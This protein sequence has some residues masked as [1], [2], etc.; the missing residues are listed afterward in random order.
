MSL[1]VCFHCP[2]S[3]DLVEP[4]LRVDTSPHDPCLNYSTHV[5]VLV[6]YPVGREDDE[7][8]MNAG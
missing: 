5:K 4:E 7:S 2:L 3:L 8:S 1:L 6:E